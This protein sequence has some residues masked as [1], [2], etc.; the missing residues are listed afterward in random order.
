MQDLSPSIRTP[1]P[2]GPQFRVSVQMSNRVQSTKSP[3]AP[4]FYRLIGG[5][6]RFSL[7]VAIN[8]DRTILDLRTVVQPTW[9]KWVT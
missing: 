2:S 8:L 4:A 6:W 3:L 5:V 7:V 1:R 9:R